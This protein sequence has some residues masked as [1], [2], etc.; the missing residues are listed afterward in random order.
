LDH[1]GSD[2]INGNCKNYWNSV[3]TRRCGLVGGSRSLGMKGTSCSWFLLSLSLSLCFLSLSL[4]L[5]LSLCLSCSSHYDASSF[6]VSY[7]SC[8]DVLP[9]YSPEKKEPSDHGLKLLK[10]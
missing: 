4:S 1:K 8:H 3:E 9:S 6:A 10:P 5:S 2:L 7:A